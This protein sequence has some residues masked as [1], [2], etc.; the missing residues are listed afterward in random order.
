VVTSPAIAKLC[1]TKFLLYC[2]RHN[3]EAQRESENLK[4]LYKIELEAKL[5]NAQAV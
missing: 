2:L 3:Y 1:K 5:N 4:K